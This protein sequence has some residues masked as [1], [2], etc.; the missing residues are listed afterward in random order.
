MFVR[1]SAFY[2][3][4]LPLSPPGAEAA[5]GGGRR[6]SRQG[7]GQGATWGEAKGDAERGGSE[8]SAVPTSPRL[9][10]RS[11]DGTGPA[12]EG[13]AGSGDGTGTCRGGPPQSWAAG[14]GAWKTRL[15]F[16]G[17]APPLL[18]TPDPARMPF[19]VTLCGQRLPRAPWEQEQQTWSSTG[20]AASA[21][22]CG[23]FLA[24]PANGHC[25]SPPQRRAP[26]RQK[27]WLHLSSERRPLVAHGVGHGR[28]YRQDPRGRP[29]ARTRGAGF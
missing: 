17:A 13:G 27:Q 19:C 5:Q 4:L 14:G 22:P 21:L 15:L 7:G 6:T 1:L 9:G 23:L 26:R 29:D 2:G 10:S 8:D 3:P 18:Q 12:V 11:R 16:Q 24:S 25:P 20:P 28:R